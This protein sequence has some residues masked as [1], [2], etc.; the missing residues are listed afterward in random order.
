MFKN[1]N[2]R[3]FL[4]FGIDETVVVVF[5]SE[6]VVLPSLNGT[7]Y[8]DSQLES[9]VWR[10]IPLYRQPVYWVIDP[11]EYDTLPVTFIIYNK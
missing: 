11:F 10:L 7:K 4:T 2:E 5:V 6:F 3:F 1:V 8:V 9:A